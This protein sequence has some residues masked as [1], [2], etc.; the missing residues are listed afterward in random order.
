MNSKGKLS[1]KDIADLLV[2]V[3]HTRRNIGF[4]D[5]GSFTDE[6][7]NCDQKEVERAERG[8]SLIK[9]VILANGI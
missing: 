7:G 8:I 9:R 6:T 5:G 3:F 1:D 2:L 4:E